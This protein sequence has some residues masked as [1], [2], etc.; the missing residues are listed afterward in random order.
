MKPLYWRSENSKDPD[1]PWRHGPL[2]RW[3]KWR[4]FDV[5]EAKE[6]LE[7][8]LWRSSA[9]SP[10]FR[11]FTYVTTYS[12]S[13][14]S[15]YLRQAH[16][17]TLPLFHLRHSSS[18]NSPGEPPMPD[19]PSQERIKWNETKWMRWMWRNCGMKFM[20]G[21]N[22]RNSEKSYRDYVSATMKHLYLPVICQIFS[23]HLS[24]WLDWHYVNEY[25]VIE[26]C[27]FRYYYWAKV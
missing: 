16:S 1:R 7:N 8:E 25:I 6:G 24:F 19:A 20:A 15:L 11:H 10:N 23:W 26:K 17:T 5:G 12:P 4:A 21:E 27:I 9:R 18:L 22:V 13:L 2:A 3:I 14:P